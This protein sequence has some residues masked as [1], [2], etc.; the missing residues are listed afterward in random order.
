[1]GC[2]V[3][4]TTGRGHQVCSRSV[5]HPRSPLPAFM[6]T[7]SF[8]VWPQAVLFVSFPAEVLDILPYL[9]LTE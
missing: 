4:N 8:E 3:M 5:L 7:V 9:A 1:M 6:F 2:D